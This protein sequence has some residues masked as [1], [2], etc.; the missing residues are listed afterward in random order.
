MSAQPN[1][2][3]EA[4]TPRYRAS[5][6][7]QDAEIAACRARGNLRCTREGQDRSHNGSESCANRCYRPDRGGSTQT[8]STTRL[9]AASGT[10]VS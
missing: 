9:T 7:M 2:L 10:L 4:S 1:A 3:H 6:E 5:I 8:A